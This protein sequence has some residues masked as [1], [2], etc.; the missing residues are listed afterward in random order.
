MVDS[1]NGSDYVH[2]RCE[3]KTTC[4]SKRTMTEDDLIYILGLGRSR[5]SY[6][7]RKPSCADLAAFVHEAKVDQHA[8]T[9]YAL[10]KSAR[11]IDHD[12]IVD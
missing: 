11:M 7:R 6:S 2:D 3:S 8:D 4:V 1:G 9:Q 12:S 10:S 5:R